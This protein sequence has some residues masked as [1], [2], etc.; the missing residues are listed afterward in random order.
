MLRSIT[1]IA[2]LS[3]VCCNALQAQELFFCEQ[4]MADGNPKGISD[5]WVVDDDGGAIYV[6]YKHYT[7]LKIKKL[8]FTI[9]KLEQGD[10]INYDSKQLY[11]DA[12]KE[13]LVLDY[14]FSEPGEYEIVVGEGDLEYVSSRLEVERKRV[15]GIDTY[16]YER[17]NIISCER[18]EEG[19]PVNPTSE[20]VIGSRGGY[21]SF[22]ID[23]NG[24]P[25]ENR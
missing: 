23:N 22:Q 7:F 6:L 17:A 14:H 12:T 21:V 11:P 18:V 1:L 9:R 3:I 20:F 24:L 16:Y 15:D 4:V 2:I 8:D 5:K 19:L 13:Y 10:Y 25:I